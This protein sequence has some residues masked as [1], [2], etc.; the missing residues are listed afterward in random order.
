MNAI[1]DAAVTHARTVVATLVLIL[2]AGTIAYITIPKE[3]DPDIN[4]P[5]LYVSMVHEGISPEDSERLLIKPM[6]Q[7]LRA[8][9]GVKEMKSTAYLGGGNVIMEFDAGFDVDEAKRDVQDKV[10]LVKPELPDDAEEPTVHEINLSLF[11]VL[12]VSLSGSVPQRTL[13]NLARDL[14]DK[15]EGISTVLSAEIS[16]D[17]EELV[18]LVIDPLALESYGLDARDII[19]AVARSNRVV[20][21]GALDTGQG[22]FAIKLPGLFESA[23]DILDMPLKT[24]DDAVVK[25]RDVGALRRTFKDSEG[26]ARING[27]RAVALE[28]SKRTGENIIETIELVRALVEAER[29]NWPAGVTVSF[30]QDKS[31]DIRNMLADLQ[32]N[33]LSAVLLV[34][35]VVVAALGLRSAAL[36]GI[37]IPGSFLSGILILAAFGFTVNIVVLFS[38]ILAV[39]MLVDGAIVVTEFA[40]RKMIEGYPKREAYAQAA[41][42]MAWPIIAATATTLAAFLPLMFWPGVVGEFMKFLPITLVATL[43]ASLLMALIFVPTLGGLIG[44]TAGAASQANMKA[45][46]AGE[47]G[48]LNDIKGLT[49]VYLKVL[50]GALRHPGLILLAAVGILIGVQYAYGQYGRGVEFFPDVEPDNAVLQIHGRGNLSIDERDFLLR[51]VE[52]RILDLQREKGEFHTVYAASQASSGTEEDEAEDVIGRIQLEFTD[53][54]NRRPA[55]EIITEIRERTAPLAGIIVEPRQQEAGPAV[56]KPIQIEVSSI[57]PALIEPVALQISQ[58]LREVDGLVDIED[59]RPIPGIEWQLRI[60]RAQA[61]KFDADVT[62]IGSYVRMITNGM[63]I[64]EFR[65]DDSIDEIDI[66]VRL[67]REYRNIAH[68]DSIRV[69]TAH[70]MI[71]IANFVTREAQPKVGLLKRV[72]GSRVMTVKADV[73]PGLLVDDKVQEVRAWLAGQEIDPRVQITFKGEDE[74]QQAAQAFLM[75]AF[76]VALFLMAIILITQFNSFYSAF[77]ILSAVIMS[78]SGVMIGLLVTDQPFGIVMSGI[79]VIALAGIVVNYNI[80]LIDTFDRL[81]K[82]SASAREAILR[83]GAQ[84]LRPVLLTTITTVLGLM[85]MVLAV[86]I[87]FFDRTLQFGAPSTQWWRQ[88]S[89]AIVFGLTFATILTLVVTPSAL[90]LRANVQGWRAR[91]RA[92]RAPSGGEAGGQLA[93]A[94]E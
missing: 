92:K 63:N 74:E 13:L 65:P 18:E 43:S 75:K 34:M 69:Q 49:G 90:M 12:V 45:M 42:R 80:V 40:D 6:E 64:G 94:G 54:F 33:V 15:V 53:W 26:Y 16:G 88:L 73:A 68:L 19:D 66:V 9:E 3:S 59:G 8:I 87:D 55:D 1:I 30:S 91:R 62:L 83:T 56:G 61:A 28:I 77:L 23:Q 22:R 48:D 89:T 32:N 82:T 72:D 60:D 47:H 71:P 38:L 51:Q 76:G 14:Q 67:P 46:A 86:N 44:K 2:I 17:R 21:A 35:I 11:P 24:N 85:P 84:R 79:G 78:T 70:G 37:A 57:N 93:P 4:I 50:G 58:A 52:D 39:G 10:D 41:K 31:T 81:K 36:V 20:A 5:I 7:E 25:F 29:Q 27:Q